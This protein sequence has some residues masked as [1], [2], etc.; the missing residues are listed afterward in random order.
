ERLCSVGQHCTL[1]GVEGVD[2]LPGDRIQILAQ[3]GSGSAIPGFP[4]SGLAET[5]DGLN[6]H[7]GDNSTT[8]STEI[9]L[10][11]PGIFRMCYCRTSAEDFCRDPVDFQARLGLLTVKGPFVQSTTCQLDNDCIIEVRGVEVAVEDQMLVTADSCGQPLAMD[12][13]G[14]AGLQRLLPLRSGPDGLQLQLGR[15]P[16]SATPG[17]YRLCWCPGDAFCTVPEDFKASGGEIHMDCPSGMYAT[18]LPPTCRVCSRG[19]HCSGGPTASAKRVPCADAETTLILGA[20]SSDA[21]VCAKGYSMSSATGRCNPCDIGFYKNTDSNEDACMPCPENYTTFT[22]GA[23][24]LSSCV[25][26]QPPPDTDVSPELPS[27]TSTGTSN[28]SVV[29]ALQLNMSVAG[30]TDVQTQ[31]QLSALILA[32][33]SETTRLD[34][35]VIQLDFG[36]DGVVA[37]SRAR[38]LTGD[39]AW[40]T[41]KVNRPTLEEASALAS[42]LDVNALLDDVTSAIQD[43]PALASIQVSVSEPEVVPV[44]ISCDRYRSVPP[45]SVALTK[46]DCQCSMG[47]GY[48][49]ASLA[50]E[51][52]GHGS[53]KP[54]TGDRLCTPCPA[55]TSTLAIG[56]TSFQEC[57]C[58]VGLYAEAGECRACRPG[59]Y[60]PG[61]GAAVECPPNSFADAGAWQEL[62]CECIAG[63]YMSGSGTCT[64]CRPQSYKPVRGNEECVLKCP[65]NANSTPAASVLEDCFCL[66]GYH[67]RFD[68]Q[69]QLFRCASCESYEGL[70]CYGGFVENTTA[71]GIHTQPV[72]DPGFFQTGELVA[73]RCEVETDAGSTC[74]GASIC[75]NGSTPCVGHYINQCTTG[76]AGMLCGECS[77][78][79]ART[80]YGE[81]C[82]P[83][84]SGVGGMVGSILGDVLQKVLVNFVLALLAA[85]AAVNKDS[86]LYTTVIRIGTQWMVALSVI[87]NFKIEHLPVFAWSVAVVQGCD[88]GAFE[89]DEAQIRFPWPSEVTAFLQEFFGIRLVPQWIS[90]HFATSCRATELYPGDRVAKMM[91]P[92]LYYVLSPFAALLGVSMFCIFLVYAVVP[93]ANSLGVEFNPDGSERRARVKAKRK[94]KAA[95]DPML[96]EGIEGP[97]FAGLKGLTWEDVEDTGMLDELSIFQLQHARYYTQDFLEKSMSKSETWIRKIALLQTM[98]DPKFQDFCDG[99]DMGLADLDAKVLGPLLVSNNHKSVDS[100]RVAAMAFAWKIIQ[101]H[102]P[103]VDQD[104]ID[105]MDV[106]VALAEAHRADP[107]LLRM[108]ASDPALL[109]EAVNAACADAAE[110]VAALTVVEDAVEA[111]AKDDHTAELP[112]GMSQID[113]ATLNFGLFTSFPRPRELLRQSMPVV[114]LTLTGIWPELL[115]EYLQLIWCSPVA[116]GSGEVVQRL[117]QHPDIVCWS[118]DHAP[119]ALIAL[120]GLLVWCAGI[121]IALF[122]TVWRT[123][124]RQSQENHRNYGYF[125]EGLEPSFW[126]WDIVVKRLDIGLMLVVAYTSLAPDDRAKLLLFPL[127]SAVQLSITCWFKPFSNDQSELLDFLEM[128]LLSSR[129]IFFASVAVLLLL[130]PDADTTQLMAGLLTGVILTVFFYFSVHAVVQLLR[131]LSHELGEE[132]Q[133][134]KPEKP[135]NK[136]VKH[137]LAHVMW[138]LKKLLSASKR[139]VVNRIFPLLQQDD[140]E[141]FMVQWSCFDDK[142]VFKSQLSSKRRR[143]NPRCPSM[144]RCWKRLRAV[145]LRFGS[146][147]QERMMAGA[148]EGFVQLWVRQFQ[149]RELPPVQ[150]VLCVL[151]STRAGVPERTKPE[152][153][154]SIWIR[155][156]ERFC[157]LSDQSGPQGHAHFALD[158]FGRAIRRLGMLPA[159]DAVELVQEV[160]QLVEQTRASKTSD[161]AGGANS[162]APSIE[163]VTDGDVCL[164]DLVERYF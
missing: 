153:L 14:F 93:L 149:Q 109:L 150:T 84:V 159:A 101:D 117:V 41:I 46:G 128:L 68:E 124:D 147:Y 51:P 115:K 91:A 164:Q 163:H 83:C 127:I 40:V 11:V 17:T 79:W 65:N 37:A 156:V 78:D 139:F 81:M 76:S 113:A 155:E 110:K 9:L 10:S 70:T 36:G 32:I 3:C 95:M 16:A 72:A 50:C 146:S 27:N 103:H 107:E 5:N 106:A 62:D 102:H 157:D 158:E 67:A 152:A 35:S 58:Q 148:F 160:C 88:R 85:R 121:P 105:L 61:T 45:G 92:G 94:L 126:W 114:W 25:L 135:S 26:V 97:G 80:A 137:D 131:E 100:K 154:A 1:A 59:F 44:V 162:I 151:A 42:E 90:V 34:T 69:G 96:E 140:D 75:E 30:I 47:Y 132:D 111:T 43:N 134:E 23:A 6:F 56:A 143:P 19:Y 55:S 74:L 120:A 89:C 21:C 15:L 104:G 125:I 73:V 38:R 48:D 119:L 31:E 86:G 136:R 60:C 52:C 142:V 54:T 4:H 63:Y 2:L 99:F 22:T 13:W 98:Q 29:S 130:N 53:Y 144:W 49:E 129:F 24:L 87:T 108:T 18:G 141:H 20:T 8:N 112:R 161:D 57:R 82:Q 28:S 123:P 33:L 39:L 64:P 118:F 116:E 12:E 138:T 77:E 7:F 66:P 145:I 133:V 122:L 71:D